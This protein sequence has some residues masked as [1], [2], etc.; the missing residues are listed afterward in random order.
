MTSPDFESPMYDPERLREIAELGL[1]DGRADEVLSGI[2]REAAA[3][4][5]LPISLVSIVLDE[6]QHLAASHGVSGWI[7]EA[8]GTPA[9]WSFCAH[10]VQSRDAFVVENAA[11]HPLMRENPLVT[12]DGIRCYA[13][14]PLISSRGFVLGNLCVIGAEERTFGEDEMGMLRGLAG[15]AVARIE[16]RRAPAS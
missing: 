9:E 2:A 13:G 5:D 12:E 3:R 14:I 6:A 4:L 16:E 15:R 8:G 1:L 10:S 11:V 7:G